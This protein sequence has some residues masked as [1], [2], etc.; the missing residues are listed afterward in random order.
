V[1]PNFHSTKDPVKSQLNSF[2]TL[3]SYLG[4]ILILFFYL[5]LVLKVVSSCQVLRLK[6]CTDFSRAHACYM[7]CPSHLPWFDQPHIVQEYKIWNSLMANVNKNMNKPRTAITCIKFEFRPKNQ[8]C[9]QIV[10][11]TDSRQAISRV[12]SNRLLLPLSS[13]SA[14]IR[15]TLYIVYLSKRTTSH[16]TAHRCLHQPQRGHATVPADPA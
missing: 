3:T 5:R 16:R 12:P 10:H 2:H 7:S 9:W 13:S 6:F 4:S 1:H 14:H 11:G 8:L 15:S